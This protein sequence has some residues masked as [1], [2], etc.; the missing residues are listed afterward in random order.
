MWGTQFSIKKLTEW[1]SLLSEADVEASLTG[2]RHTGLKIKSLNT[3]SNS[4]T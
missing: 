4:V 3:S 2:S 1:R